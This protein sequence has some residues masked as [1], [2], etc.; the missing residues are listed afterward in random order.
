[1]NADLSISVE[2]VSLS[3]SNFSRYAYHLDA[4][5][6]SPITV[7]DIRNL[8]ARVL[9]ERLQEF[10]RAASDADSDDEAKTQVRPFRL[11][12]CMR[13]LRLGSVT[14]KCVC[15]LQALVQLKRLQV[16]LRDSKDLSQRFSA[17]LQVIS[18]TLAA[19]Q[20]DG[21]G[22]LCDSSSSAANL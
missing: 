18:D 20:G 2:T 10:L 21:G 11:S 6:Y 7:P 9:Q 15:P 5:D 14:S 16:F 1:M 8:E 12:G 19:N 22:H 3:F 4:Y 13:E 17:E